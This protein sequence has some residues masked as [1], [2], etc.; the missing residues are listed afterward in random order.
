MAPP[1]S[2]ATRAA[3]PQ[4]QPGGLLQEASEEL[5][6]AANRQHRSP[7]SCGCGLMLRVSEEGELV[8]DGV[9]PGGPADKTGKLRLGDTLVRVDRQYVHGLQ[10]SQIAPKILGPAGSIVELGFKRAQGPVVLTVNVA[11]V[12]GVTPL[13]ASLAGSPA[14][15]SGSPAHPRRA[16]SGAAPASARSLAFPA[17][18]AAAQGRGVG[19]AG[20]A[21]RA[22]VPALDTSALSVSMLSSAPGGHVT[23]REGVNPPTPGDALRNSTS[24]LVPVPVGSPAHDGSSQRWNPRNSA[25]RPVAAGGGWGEERGGGASEQRDF[26]AGRRTGRIES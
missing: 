22:G 5:L 3:A 11:I 8:V 1:R 18:D 17:H 13:P 21:G 23:Q 14:H 4:P 25:R 19:G 24:S 15:L 7:E 6:G 20:P 12:R 2:A 16:A 10:P 9:L 26:P